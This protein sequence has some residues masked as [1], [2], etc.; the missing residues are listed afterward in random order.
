MMYCST[1]L[2][3]FQKGKLDDLVTMVKSQKTQNNS[4]GVD[5]DENVLYAMDKVEKAYMSKTEHGDSTE[6][7]NK[8]SKVVPYM[9]T[10]EK[11]SN[12]ESE[13]KGNNTK[14][15]SQLLASS[16]LV[17]EVV[18]AHVSGS[19]ELDFT[20]PWETP[21]HFSTPSVQNGSK[22]KRTSPRNHPADDRLVL[23]PKFTT[24]KSFEKAKLFQAILSSDEEVEDKAKACEGETYL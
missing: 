9:T 2:L 12:K 11:H 16:D 7:H 4:F 6:K 8:D 3:C 24:A 13:I 15:D 19:I 14:L 22:A 18:K 10:R 1:L 23:T 5:F 17:T 21:L 20:G